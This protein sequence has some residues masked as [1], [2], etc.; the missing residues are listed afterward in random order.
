[1]PRF[2]SQ[3]KT[4]CLAV[5]GPKATAIAQAM[6]FAWKVRRKSKQ[7]PEFRFASAVLSPGDIAIDVGANGADW[8]H[9]LSQ[10]IGPN[11]IVLAFE[12]DPYYALATRL[13]I[14][15]LGLKNVLFFPFGL[16]DSAKSA[17]LK[18]VHANGVRMSGE[19]HIQRDA[20]SND[21]TVQEIE[22]R[23]LDS[24][25]DECPKLLETRLF[26]IDVEG[27]ELFVLRGASRILSEARPIVILEVGNYDRFGYDEED[28]VNVFRELK[29]SWFTAVNA[30]RIEPTDGSLQHPNAASVNRIFVPDEK[31]NEIEPF[32]LP[33]GIPQLTVE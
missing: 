29:Y 27:F 24:M 13:A 15:F 30:V 22:L 5:F 7:D 18:V 1:M 2:L 32:L 11:G 16:S 3:I 17:Y 28:I 10:S 4:G 25:I 20:T 23:T 33:N 8:T 12:A 21:A 19:G 26:K 6:R 9:H 31:L 14:K